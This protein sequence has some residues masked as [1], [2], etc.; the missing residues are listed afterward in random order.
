VLAALAIV[1]FGSLGS[2]QDAI[3]SGRAVDRVSQGRFI[4]WPRDDAGVVSYR[5]AG[6]RRRPPARP[7][8]YLLGG[9]SMRE[10]FVSP[11]SLRRQVKARS[12]VDMRVVPLA[13][14][15]QHLA[16]SL[17]IVDALPAGQGGI[18][19]VGLHHTPFAYGVRGATR[20]LHGDQLMVR[21][22]VL[23]DFLEDRLGTELSA[24]LRPGLRRHVDDYERRRGAT[25]FTGAAIEH[26]AHRYPMSMATSD[27]FKRSRVTEWLAGRGRPGGPFFRNF[28]LNAAILEELIET[29]RAKGFQVLIMESPQNAAFIGDAFDPYKEKYRA[30]AL[31]MRD[32][33]GAHYVNL[34]RVVG[35]LRTDFRDL[36]HLLP[37]GYRKWQPRLA[38]TLARIIADHPPVTPTPSP[39]PS[40]STSASSGAPP[41]A[42]DRGILASL[43]VAFGSQGDR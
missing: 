34:N 15:E 21:S 8:V 37:T 39:S 20:Q 40:D 26:D 14:S 7:A 25:A 33:N 3:V 31:E 11:A 28:A 24:D 18:I 9:S 16:G 32:T 2:L 27:A 4:C 41:A 1:P 19:V 43:E 42:P 13:S 38:D 12:G 5:V 10:C 17:A 35:L 30:L 29:A 22:P 23:R 6:L 36:L